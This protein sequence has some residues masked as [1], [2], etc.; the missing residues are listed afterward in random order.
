MRS[1]DDSNR[2]AF[3]LLF[4]RR[5]GERDE[6]PAAG[7][8]DVAGPWH[9]EEIPGPSGETSYGLFRAGGGLPLALARPA[10]RGSLSRHGA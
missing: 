6:P 7:E 3:S 1:S 4:L 5:I 2:N 9:L 8:A 10:G